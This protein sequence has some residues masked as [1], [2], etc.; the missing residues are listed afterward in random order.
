MRNILISALFLCAAASA[1]GSDTDADALGVGAECIETM[2]CDVENGQAC[3]A[4]FKGGY[5]GIK[6]CLANA[7]CPETSACVAHTDGTNYCF[8]SCLDK[9]E[10][11]EN[12][13][14][15]QESNCSSNI[16]FVEDREDSLKACVPPAN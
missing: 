3:L 13:S 5:C 12:R 14:E 16:T 6:D 2:E 15:E 10:C 8:R 9:A 7:D 4:E 1:C 11:N